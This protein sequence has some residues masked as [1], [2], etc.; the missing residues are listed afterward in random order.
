VSETSSPQDPVWRQIKAW[1]GIALPGRFGAATLKEAGVVITPRHDL[2]LAHVIASE[3][4]QAQAVAWFSQK[5]A[6]EAPTAPR[7]VSQGD[8]TLVWSGPCQWL[9]LSGKT[10]LPRRLAE[11][12]GSVLAVTDQSEGRAVLLLEGAHVRDALA[13]G[14]PIDLHPRRFQR[15]DAALT[16]I[17]GIGAQIWQAPDSDAVY[18]VVARSMTQSFWSWLTHSAAEFGVEVKPA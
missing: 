3:R 7:A 11:E 12:A 9:A 13:K 16:V 14:C 17:A 6:I 5:F 8:L 1:D 18:I 4:D 2:A 15:G 10:N